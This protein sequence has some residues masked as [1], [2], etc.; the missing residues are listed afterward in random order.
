MSLTTNSALLRHSFLLVIVKLIDEQNENKWNRSAPY[1]LG[2]EMEKSTFSSI[3]REV[4]YFFDSF[5]II[6]Q[7]P[8]YLC[9]L[10]SSLSHPTDA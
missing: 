5:V 6:N 10:R 2:Q 7:A 3:A 8:V 1:K 9:N 4:G